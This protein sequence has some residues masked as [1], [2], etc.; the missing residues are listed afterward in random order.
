MVPGLKAPAKA[1]AT[2][3]SAV[4]VVPSPPFHL[5]DMPRYHSVGDLAPDS[6][7]SGNGHGGTR[8]GPDWCH[9]FSALGW[10]TSL[11]TVFIFSASAV[12]NAFL[13]ALNL[14][15][16]ATADVLMLT[17]SLDS[18]HFWQFPARTRAINITSTLLLLVIV[19]MYVHLLLTV[20]AGPR[21]P[22]A[23]RESQTRLRK[24]LR[25]AGTVA[26]LAS[27]ASISEKLPL[28]ALRRRSQPIFSKLYSDI[29]FTDGKYRKIWV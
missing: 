18:G 8:Y 25:S 11:A 29:L 24:L 19:A 15:P 7:S 1:P 12:W 28:A 17:G 22:R 27:G 4:A 5:P 13:I 26:R 14:S 20:L 6:S 10:G 3:K 9:R 23:T 16:N 2:A 21:K